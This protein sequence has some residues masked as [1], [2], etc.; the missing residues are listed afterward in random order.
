MLSPKTTNPFVAISCW[1]TSPR[2]TSVSYL[3]GELLWGILN[4][5]TKLG[6]RTVE[7]GYSRICT[8][9]QCL[10]CLV[11]CP[12]MRTATTRKVIELNNAA[13]FDC[14]CVCVYIIDYTYILRMLPDNDVVTHLLTL[15]LWRIP[16]LSVPIHVWVHRFRFIRFR[17][18]I[19][20][21][22][23]TDFKWIKWAP[24]CPENL[25]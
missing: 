23:R 7:R 2:P 4:R 11:V 10:L 15:L 8:N 5:T 19:Y 9:L 1:P 12:A 20:R 21:I 24:L 14:V 16:R 13:E 17:A 6:R 18:I 3:D 22:Y 25:D